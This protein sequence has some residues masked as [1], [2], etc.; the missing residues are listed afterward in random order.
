MPFVF[1]SGGHTDALDLDVPHLGAYVHVPFC[2]SL[3]PF[4]PYHKERYGNGSLMPLYLDA[5]TREIESVLDDNDMRLTS[6]YFGGGSPALA[7]EGIS[8]ILDAVRRHAII[9]GGVGVELHPRDVDEQTLKTLLEAGVT[10]VSL[11]VQSFDS[12]SLA[13]LGRSGDPSRSRDALRMLAGVG[14]DVIDVDLIFGIP[15]QGADVLARDFKQACDL[16]ATQISTYPFIDFSYASNRH[17]PVS[18]GQKRALM[19]ELLRA[20][21]VNG[22]E[23]GSVW[24]FRRRGTAAYSSVTRDNFVGFG[25]SATTLLRDQF[26]INTFDVEAYARLALSGKSPTA[27]TLKFSARARQAYWLFWSCYNMDIGRT[28]F[29]EL[30]NEDLDAAFGTPLRFARLLGIAADAEDGYTLSATGAYLYHVVEQVYTRQYIDK[31][32]RASMAQE[33]PRRIVL[34]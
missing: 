29:Q 2:E 30:F 32:W 13:A 4:C 27:Y 3:C 7:G 19:S 14:F 18:E 26:K 12:A 6:V 23:R 28:R 25:P 21:D 33:P 34:W 16:G 24:T 1:E 9:E 20:A 11:G 17:R 5:V 22:F 31:T 15:G 8:H 10:M